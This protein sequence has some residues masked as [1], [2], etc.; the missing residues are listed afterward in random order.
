[1]SAKYD[2]SPFTLNDK[3]LLVPANNELE[4]VVLGIML[5]SAEAVA[6]G[7]TLLKEEYFPNINNSNRAIFHAIRE[8]YM[9]QSEVDLMT[10]SQ[11][12]KSMKMFAAVGGTAYLTALAEEAIAFSAFKNYCKDLREA[13]LLRNTLAVLDKN[14]NLHRQGNTGNPNDFVSEIT[15]EITKVAEERRIMDFETLQDLGEDLKIHLEK[16]RRSGSGTVT[17]LATGFSELDR[18]THGFQED[19]YIIVAARPSVGKTAFALSLAYNIATKNDKTV[20]FFSAEMGSIQL[21]QRL[22]SKVSQINHGQITDGKLDLKQRTKIDETLRKLDNVKLLIDETPNININDLILKTRKLKRE[23]DDLSCII[24]DYIGLITPSRKVE[25]R[26][27][28]LSEISSALKALARELKITVVALSQLSRTVEARP[29][30][31]PQMSDLRESGSLEQDADLVF[32]MY[33]EDYYVNQGTIKPTNAIYQSYYTTMSERDAER[34]VSPVDII[35][36]KNRS[37]E[38]GSI[39]LF[40]F[41]TISS[42]E[43]PDNE[44]L[45]LLKNLQRAN[46]GKKSS[47]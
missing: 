38:T 3:S 11:K 25:N 40:F 37:G 29:D 24:V 35:L 32:L 33:R 45:L 10:V 12:L 28:E 46:S 42:F 27:L 8:L 4:A 39:I 23:H 6:E 9:E 36:A 31:R 20:G 22:L 15:H 19:N 14:L 5:N 26:Q 7:T 1:M 41:K 30:K 47:D 16:M 18:I 43:T 17:G 21:M 13:A 44:T 34:S 2:N